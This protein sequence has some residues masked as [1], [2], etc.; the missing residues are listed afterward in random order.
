MEVGPEDPLAR[1]TARL[2]IS[3]IDVE[4]ENP[5][6]QVAEFLRAENKSRR[7]S[8]ISLNSFEEDEPK[9]GP[10]PK[11]DKRRRSSA[12][13]FSLPSNSKIAN[14]GK[15]PKK[16]HKKKLKKA[17]LAP[18]LE[19]T[20]GATWKRLPFKQ[21]RELVLGVFTKS[22]NVQKRER[23]YDIS[24]S[25]NV[26][27]LVFC[28]V[29]GLP[30]PSSSEKDEEGKFYVPINAA[31]LAPEF[32]FIQN[33]DQMIKTQS[34][35]SKDLTYP[36]LQTIT[37]IQLT[38]NE[39]KEILESLKASKITI[40]DLLLSP[41]QLAQNRY[42][43]DISNLEGWVETKDFEH[44]GSHT[45]ALDCEFCQAASGKVLTRISLI[46]FQGEVLLDQFVKPEEEI[47]DYLTKYSGI[48]EEK[49]KD[50]TT[51]LKDVQ[52]MVLEIVAKGD[53]LIGHSLESDLNVMRI[54][55]EK[56]CDTSLVYQ[57][58]KG[59]PL[60]PSL[61]WLSQKYLARTIQAG[62]A[63]GNGHSSVEDA[64]ACLDLVK[65]KIIEGWCFGLNVGEI[66]IFHRLAKEADIYNNGDDFKSLWID[67]SN[68]KDQ[69]SYIE[70]AEY[71]V[72][73][74][75]ANNDDE[76]VKNYKEAHD[77]KNFT[78]LSLKELEYNK[79]L[80]SVPSHFNGKIIQDPTEEQLSS[81]YKETNRRL[82]EIYQELPEN[83]IMI[84][85]STV[86][87]PR[88][89]YRLQE[90]KRV[91]QKK[92]REGEDLKAL[93]KEDVWDIDKQQALLEATEKAKKAIS[94]I[95]IKK[96]SKTNPVV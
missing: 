85:N 56:I 29:P 46:N 51:T 70:P 39:K 84:I 21:L 93:P 20:S 41:G 53:I 68:Y 11:G 12:Q 33:F 48:T 23:W 60:K 6:L 50:V 75:Y 89:M 43:I 77:K 32:D 52:K 8:A 22:N 81:L 44:E 63:T 17:T 38:K 4:N 90:V 58:S 72:I 96:L 42:P 27:S 65:L 16:V 40:N 71:N 14:T 15:S 28:L 7:D 67:Y 76:V 2:S 92:E 34:P 88:E 94:F 10:P 87:D 37:N 62:E 47:T 83:S 35:G 95:G 57:H 91:F 79:G 78:V 86:G 13:S 54:K 30:S 59:P 18:E 3:A 24:N 49:L 36:P 61:R 26:T 66:S 19:F 45:F 1:S 80:C 82:N 69:E 9:M 31:N 64:Q 74:L 55:H 5:R 25:G 73:K